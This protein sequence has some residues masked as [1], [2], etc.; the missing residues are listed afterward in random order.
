MLTQ[1]CA[2]LYMWMIAAWFSG[3]DENDLVLKCNQLLVKLQSRSQSNSIKTN[4]VKS[5]A[6]LF[7]PRNIIFQ[8]KH[9]LQF[10]G[11]EIELVNEHKIL[12]VYFSRHLNWEFLVNRLRSKLSATAGMLSACRTIMPTK[13]KIQ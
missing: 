2:S 5:K 10:S 12:G 3:C 13:T 11:T 8:L 9:L 6:I 4:P 7:R 1:P